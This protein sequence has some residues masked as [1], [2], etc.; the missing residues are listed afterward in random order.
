MAQ[1]IGENVIMKIVLY[2]MFPNLQRGLK[3]ENGKN[4]LHKKPRDRLKAFAGLCVLGGTAK[5]C[6]RSREVSVIIVASYLE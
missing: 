4:S 2:C 5:T 1:S 3:L 6:S